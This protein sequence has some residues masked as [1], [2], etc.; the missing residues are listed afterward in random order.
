MKKI[1]LLTLILIYFSFETIAQKQIIEQ[2]AIQFNYAF[3]EIAKA[4]AKNPI[5]VSPR[6]MRADTLFMVP[7]KDWTSG[8]FAGN[9]WYMYELTN[10]KKWLQRAQEFTAPIENQKMDSTTHDLGFKLY[11]SFGNGYRLTKTPQYRDVLLQSARTLTTRFN[12]KV[13]SLRSWDHHKEVWQFP[14]IIDN[15][16]NLEL[17]FWAFKETKDSTFYKVAVSHANTTMK[18]HYRVDFSSYHVVDYD[19][20]TGQV[21]KKNT[22]Q[23]FS[24]ESAWARG[25]AWGLYAF[26]MCYR[27]TG[28]K[29]YLQ[30]AEN[31]ANFILKHP[32]L[33]TDLV[34]Y[35]DYNAPEI[36]N[37]PR[38]VSAAALMASAFYEMST[39]I[40]EKSEFYRKTADKIM[41][42]IAEKY[43]AA[44][45]TNKGFLLTNSTGHL[46]D[47]TEINVPIVYADYY[48]LEALLRKKN[49]DDIPQTLH[50]NGAILAQ[51]KQLVNSDAVKKNALKNFLITADRI[52]KA[53]KVYSVMN[54]K[55]VPPSGDKHD[56]MS[57][58]PYWWADSTKPN[59]LP[60]IRRDGV[61]NPELN[62]ISDHGDMSKLEEDAQTTALAY[63]FT[64]DEHYA[65]HAARLIKTWFLDKE[66]RQNP[67][68]NFGQGIPGINT[69]R[70]IGII[71]TRNIY[72]FID[73]AILLR[74][75]KYWSEADHNALKKWFSDYL[76]WLLE[77]PI[78]KDEA[79]EHNNHGTYYDVQ[80]IALALFTGKP[81]LAKK[82]I[83]TTKS[84]MASQLKPDGSQP[85]EL[86]RTTSWNY[87][88]MNLLGFFNT[89]RLAENV[90]VDLWKYET[91]DGKSL[92]KCVD[93]LLPYLK[94]EKKWGYEQIK[95]MEYDL[96]FEILKTAAKK[97]Q[98]PAYDALA[99]QVDVETYQS[100]L[101]QLIF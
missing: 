69:G 24:H 11:C 15:M 49:L 56:Y 4:K 35:W 82:Q 65:Q 91:K 68:L 63:Y 12:E 79:D 30:H 41:A 25:Q 39:L 21:T 22:H 87:T 28:D 38:D 36:P 99:K 54:K 98:N 10:D 19:E 74:G 94:K 92:Q 14:V 95:K 84:R 23:G 90:N 34:P 80:V 48:Y 88:N 8:F 64:Q 18:N 97:Y 58:A 2:A 71:E 81:D 45:K 50:L 6:S 3:E 31:I 86:V 13:G 57:Q 76:T 40:P 52:V 72:Q 101:G 37:A 59:G 26:T 43:T 1:S 55:I 51:N 16:M 44:P 89:A 60:Y 46:P 77:S 93:W 96:T 78:G 47:K 20:K 42:S 17:L 61:R 32:N 9:L 75:S 53:G 33:P 66:T 85:H 27:E 7:A 62:K 83:D 29:K 100:D 5:A 67:N 73:A 70:G